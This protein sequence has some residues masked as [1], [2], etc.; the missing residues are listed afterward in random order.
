MA[1][2]KVAG[3]RLAKSTILLLKPR[4]PMPPSERSP[5]SAS[6]SGSSFIARTE[7][8]SQRRSRKP[9]SQN[10]RLSSPPPRQLRVTHYAAAFT[11]T[12]R[13]LFRG[14]RPTMGVATTS[15]L[16]GSELKLRSKRR[17]MHDSP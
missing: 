1:P 17:P 14:H 15:M 5:H 12:I 3:P 8:P 2:V 9:S 6:R 13:P 16:H 10:H 7:P 11:P 4:R